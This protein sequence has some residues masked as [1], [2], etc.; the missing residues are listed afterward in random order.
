[1]LSGDASYSFGHSSG[2]LVFVLVLL[3]LVMGFAGYKYCSARLDRNT[4]PKFG[5]MDTLIGN[6]NDD[7]MENYTL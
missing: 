2:S 3:L 7:T 5:E 1:M 6:V 4:I